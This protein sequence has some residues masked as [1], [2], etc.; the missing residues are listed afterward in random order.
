VVVSIPKVEKLQNLINSSS[1]AFQNDIIQR[2]VVVV[3][4]LAIYS[5]IATLQSPTN[6]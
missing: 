6:G 1:L 2:F 3:F 5:E 4:V